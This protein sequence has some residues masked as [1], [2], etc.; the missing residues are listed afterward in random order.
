[1]SERILIDRMGT[2]GTIVTDDGD[3]VHRH[4]NAITFEFVASE[5]PPPGEGI[6]Q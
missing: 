6:T 5:P 3:G 1:M 4:W 2:H